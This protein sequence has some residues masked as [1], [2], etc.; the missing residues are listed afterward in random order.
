[1]NDDDDDQQPDNGQAAMQLAIETLVA[2]MLPANL[3][4]HQ[5]ATNCTKEIAIRTLA[6]AMRLGH[7][8]LN[9]RSVRALALKI[10]VSHTALARRIRQLPSELE[11][12]GRTART[13]GVP[14]LPT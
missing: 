3:D 10:G 5:E 1:M 14:S 2:V 12:L 13:K 4:N 7:Y 9:G 11:Q 8:R 6:L